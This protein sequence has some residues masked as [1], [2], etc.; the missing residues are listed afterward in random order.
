[1]PRLKQYFAKYVE[2]VST[3]CTAFAQLGIFHAV[4]LL[5]QLTF[6]PSI[7][8]PIIRHPAVCINRRLR[9]WADVMMPPPSIEREA[10]AGVQP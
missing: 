3:V 4:G 5:R 2:F 10:A 9:S 8:S 6:P 1:M 7:S